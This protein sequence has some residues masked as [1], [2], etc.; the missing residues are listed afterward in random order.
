MWIFIPPRY[1][2]PPLVYPGVRGCR[3]LILYCI[4]LTRLITVHYFCY[5]KY[6]YEWY[7]RFRIL[8]YADRLWNVHWN[9]NIL[10][11]N[12]MS[13]SIFN[14][15][16]LKSNDSIFQQ[17]L[18]VIWC[19]L[20]LFRKHPWISLVVRDTCTIFR[21]GPCKKHIDASVKER[22]QTL[23]VPS[24]VCKRVLCN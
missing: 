2:I 5:F 9:W 4:W 10:W 11:K 7:I 13:P 12:K 24:K 20:W 8:Q 18:N 3:A 23:L 16:S 15:C 1:L 19:S 6:L 17:K 21:T 14:I 22:P